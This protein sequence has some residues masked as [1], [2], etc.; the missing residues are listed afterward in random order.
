M[1]MGLPGY[2]MVRFL[3]VCNAKN[4]GSIYWQAYSGDC[5]CQYTLA[6][7]HGRGAVKVSELLA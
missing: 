1:A 5:Y 6:L 3:N 7:S 4:A 2:R